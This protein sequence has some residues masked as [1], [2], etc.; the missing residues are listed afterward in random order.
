MKDLVDRL[1]YYKTTVELENRFTYDFNLNT[2][3]FTE[4]EKDEINNESNTFY[5]NVKL[6][7]LIKEKS[8][9]SYELTDLNFWI[10]NEWGGIQTFKR[11]EKNEKKIRTFS[12]Q[13]LK[14]KLTKDTFETISS[15]S[16]ISSFIDPDNYVIYD[17]RV[18]YAINWILMTTSQTEIKYFPMPTGRNRKLADFDINT[19]I[20]LTHLDGYNS[21][22]L[23]YDHKVAY[24]AFCELIKN[25]CKSVFDD[26]TIKPYY[27]EMLL[28][29]IADNEIY[30]ELT[31]QIKIEIKPNR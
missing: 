9:N 30:N 16:K 31:T 8:K 14:S 5:K 29:T 17:S 18:I 11:N 3:L 6:K 15:L 12:T 21:G 20:N 23:F 10:V 28:F 24:F 27:L 4:T 7:E 13:L 25:L 19:I 22:H 2:T 26:E 1:K